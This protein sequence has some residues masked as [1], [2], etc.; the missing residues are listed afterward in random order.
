MS[1][2]KTQLSRL[3][4]V[5]RNYRQWPFDPA[6]LSFLLLMSNYRISFKIVALIGVYVWR[7]D[8]KWRNGALVWFYVTLPVLALVN[9]FFVSGDLSVSHIVAVLVCVGLWLAALLAFRQVSL[10][11]A[12][13]PVVKTETTLKWLAGINLAVSLADLI[14]IMLATQSLNPYTQISPPP[15]GISSGDLIGGAFGGMHLVNTAICC[16]LCVFFIY[17]GSL[18]FT[19]ISLTPFLLTGS[20]LGT[21]ILCALLGYVLFFKTGLVYKTIAVFCLLAVIVYYNKITPDNGKYM[22]SVLT[23][24]PAHLKI[25]NKE[26]LPAK[27]DSEKAGTIA[28]IP[29]KRVYTKDELINLYLQ[30]LRKRNAIAETETTDKLQ[31]SVLSSFTSYA[32]KEKKER[33]RMENKVFYL[34]D[35][36]QKAKSKKAFFDYGRLKKFDLEHEAGKITSFKQTAAYLSSGAAAFLFGAGAG[37]FS[38]RQAFIT[39]G[40]VEDSRLLMLLP[41]YET[42]EFKNNHEAIFKYLMFRDDETHSITNLPFCWYNQ[43]LGEYGILGALA[44]FVLYCGFFIKRYRHLS[45]GRM[46]L[47]ALLMFFLFDYWYERLSVV[48]IFE[49]LMLLDMK[50]REEEQNKVQV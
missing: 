21:L 46:L 7:P 13:L 14:K 8:F 44:F 16:M 19:L 20:N 47:P 33:G 4:E 38:S 1:G 42:F 3:P 9:L 2:I 49:L 11:I 41:H 26:E 18:V 6:L 22:T 27:V 50:I 39:S 5:I 29:Q 28:L 37:S 36:V 30:Y 40:I 10:F 34:K 12:Q 15:Y 23:K 32:N 17:R 45:Y 35:S 43:M 31:T 24:V 48:I 25:K